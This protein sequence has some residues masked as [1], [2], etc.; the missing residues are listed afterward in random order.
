[1]SQPDNNQT[2]NLCFIFH[3]VSYRNTNQLYLR[4]SVQQRIA[5]QHR[6]MRGPFVLA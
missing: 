3:V 1:M 2:V 4:R 6:A 5:N